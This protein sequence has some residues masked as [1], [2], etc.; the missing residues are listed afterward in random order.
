EE[1][2]VKGDAA[3]WVEMATAMRKRMLELQDVWRAS[4]IEKPLQSR[5]GIN[6]GYCTVGNFG[7]EDRMDYTII[8]GGVNLAS[9]LEAAAT[10]GEILISFETHANRRDPIHS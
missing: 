3:A 7:S 6:T 9:R 10:P 8:G 4:G 2:G 5:I 1:R